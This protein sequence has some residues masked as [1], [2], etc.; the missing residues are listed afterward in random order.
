MLLRKFLPKEEEL[1]GMDIMKFVEEMLPDKFQM[2]LAIA[3]MDLLS[4]HTS[5]EVYL[6][7]TSP[8]KK[9]PLIED[10]ELIIQE[11]FKEFRENLKA[12]ERNIKER[13]KEYLLMNRWGYAK[14]PYKL[15]YP[16][17]PKSLSP[18]SKEKGKHHLEK[19]DI[20][21]WGIP[22]SISI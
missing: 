20:N 15:L 7:Q 1:E 6:G 14:I 18:T 21:E 9:W 17:T 8:Q 12:I 10:Y 11:K 13:N 5:D 16:D 2:K 19:T 3:V 22:N 4:R